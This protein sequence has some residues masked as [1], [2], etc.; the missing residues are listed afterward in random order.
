MVQPR[1]C[2]ASK[3]KGYAQRKDAPP[4]VGELSDRRVAVDSP[5]GRE[6]AG[7]SHIGRLH[8][9]GPQ[10]LSEAELELLGRHVVRMRL[11]LDLAND[12]VAQRDG[13]DVG[14]LVT[15]IAR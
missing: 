2:F 7:G 6:V 8:R 15:R 12:R 11:E 13:D 14:G 3:R 10:D 1:N 9:V 5:T 4:S